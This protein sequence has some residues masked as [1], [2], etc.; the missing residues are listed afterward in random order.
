MGM[1]MFETT[2]VI[3]K[4]TYDE[5]KWHLLSQHDKFLFA[6]GVI[7]GIVITIGGVQLARNA[8]VLLGIVITILF[9]MEAF[10]KPRRYVKIFQQRAKEREGAT[11]AKVRTAF[12]ESGIKLFDTADG[13]S[14]GVISYDH[15]GKF[16]ETKNLY[17][18][19]TKAGQMMVA[20][21]TALIQTGE[22]EAFQQ[23]IKAKLMDAKMKPL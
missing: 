16:A 20:N 3:T 11:D 1:E 19:M 23:F 22:N 8:T 14:T 21:K 17:F 12:T 18:F 2:C 10:L 5:I 4:D 15:I 13:K 9:I 7:C 6:A